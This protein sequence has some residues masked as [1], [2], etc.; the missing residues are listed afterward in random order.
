[1]AKVPYVVAVR[2]LMYDAMGRRPDI[3]FAVQELSQYSS[4]PGHR[5]RSV[6]FDTYP[7]PE[8]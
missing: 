6:L 3:A 7:P 2:S 1:M 5:R 8:T 4:N